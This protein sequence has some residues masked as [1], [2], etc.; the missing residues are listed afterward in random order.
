[1]VNAA[2]V[3]EEDMPKIKKKKK[4]DDI[5]V[6]SSPIIMTQGVVSPLIVVV[7]VKS[8]TQ[9]YRSGGIGKPV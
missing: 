9:T 1:L 6:Y 2:T 7:V 5:H 4:K 8:I 3:L